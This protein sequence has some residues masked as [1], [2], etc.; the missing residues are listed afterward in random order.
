MITPRD[1]QIAWD[2]AWNLALEDAARL[3]VSLYAKSPASARDDA[4]LVAASKIR[5][6]KRHPVSAGDGGGR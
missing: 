3:C 6:M 4:L 1:A 2:A 5:D